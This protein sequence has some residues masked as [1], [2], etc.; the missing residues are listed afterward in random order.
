MS[1]FQA[2][3]LTK[4]INTIDP[5]L[6][7][8]KHKSLKNHLQGVWS[9]SRALQTNLRLPLNPGLVELSSLTHDIGKTNPGFQEYLIN[10]EITK[11]PP[12]AAPSSWWTLALSSEMGLTLDEAFWA[13]E[14]VRRHHTGLEDFYTSVLNYWNDDAAINSRLNNWR[15]AQALM[16]DYPI[17]FEENVLRNFDD[18]FWDIDTDPGIKTW[19]NFRLLYSVLIAS[20]RMDAVGINELNFHKVSE[21]KLPVFNISNSPINHWRQQ[22]QEECFSFA[23]ESITEPGIYSLTLPTG[24]GK[25]ITGLR[26]AFS[27]IHRYKLSSLIYILPFISIVEQTANVARQ[28]FNK[29]LIQEDHSLVFMGAEESSTLWQHIFTQFRYWYQPILISTMAQL[30]DSIFNPRANHTMNFHRLANAVII[31]DEPQTLPPK[32]WQGLGELLDFL[33]KKLGSY[34]ILMTATQPHISRQSDS[35]SELTP[36][37]F[38]FPKVRHRYYINNINSPVLYK[39]LKDLFLE[40]NLIETS[41]VGLI[42]L[43]TKRSALEVFK[44]VEDLFKDNDQIE[45]LFLST[46]LTPWRR[47]SILEHLKNLERK[48]IPRILISTQ[49]VEAGVDLDFNWVIRDFG[50]LDSIIQVAGRCNRHGKREELGRVFV[51][52][53]KDEL[54]HT[55]SGYVYDKVLLEASRDI[56]KKYSQFD[57]NDVPNMVDTY[58]R[59]ILDRLTPEDI[60]GNLNTG[61][62]GT[63]PELYPL[64]S[65]PQ[66]QL[67]IEESDDVNDL[68]QILETTNWCLE[69]I[70]RKKDAMRQLQQYVIEIPM[71]MKPILDMFCAQIPHPEPLLR[72]ILGG[73]MLLLSS[74]L[75]NNGTEKFLY[76]KVKGFLP[77]EGDEMSL[78]F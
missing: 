32:Y 24:A 76:H 38:R 77:P 65:E 45:L 52:H 14:A 22:I 20:D 15:I 34:F 61:K 58:Y 26:I 59:M 1:G 53:L 63:T 66:I 9:L 47:R 51:T 12:H 42:V 37:V 31:L 39:D 21:I 30:W 78:V 4:F 57:E 8:H 18:L 2:G 70:H 29:D 54:D 7:S 74:K 28:C 71:K 10:D 17:D 6:K 13:A 25:T 50:P 36:R 73:Q 11:G 72:E 75:I 67:V 64:K 68:V 35:G 43:N 60:I 16:P 40:H 46:W 48:E 19:L 3:K 49:V 5:D 55:Y 33:A 62:W 27:L 56:L 69:N 41:P 44:L 23:E